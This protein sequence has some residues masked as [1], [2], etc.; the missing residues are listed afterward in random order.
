MGQWES[1]KIIQWVHKPSL[2]S[3]SLGFGQILHPKN[4]SN[5]IIRHLYPFIDDFRG[6]KLETFNYSN[7]KLWPPLIFREGNTRFLASHGPERYTTGPVYGHPARPPSPASGFVRPTKH[8]PG[9]G[10]WDGPSAPQ[11]SFNDEFPS[12]HRR[13]F[14]YL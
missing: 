10:A 12:S 11:D 8:L 6:S 14:L 4:G 5:G 1:H 7:K 9:A 3:H 2:T 13:C